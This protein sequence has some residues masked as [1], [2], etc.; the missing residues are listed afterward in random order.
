VRSKSQDGCADKWRD[1]WRYHLTGESDGSTT[2]GKVAKTK[3][4][5]DAVEIQVPLVRA[6]G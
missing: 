4:G 2:W 1:N 3:A 6:D 5:S